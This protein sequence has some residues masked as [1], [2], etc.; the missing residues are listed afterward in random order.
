VVEN[1][2]DRLFVEFSVA[3]LN[4]LTR[5]IEDCL[6]RLGQDKIWAR[7]G[8]TENSVGNLVL[9]LCGNVR[10]WVVSGIGGAPDSRDRDGEFAARDTADA[11][12]LARMLR[13]AVSDAAAVLD[14]LTAE[15][16]CETV[17]IQS[18]DS[19][20]LAAVY[21]VVEHFSQHAGQIIFA[22]KRATGED[23]GYYRHLRGKTHRETTP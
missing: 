9:H 20:V 15:R 12:E 21:H 6:G 22:T 2:I 4:Q 16:L 13:S 18:Y 8:E 5:R 14:R 3:K 23:L 7:G 1:S 10:Q 11:G 17:R 19:S